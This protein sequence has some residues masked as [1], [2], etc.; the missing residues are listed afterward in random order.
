MT[1]AMTA[2][3][4]G[5]GCSNTV[6]LLPPRVAEIEHSRSWASVETYLVSLGWSLREGAL[7]RCPSCAA[8]AALREIIGNAEARVGGETEISVCVA[9]R[10]EALDESDWRVV[11]RLVLAGRDPG[12]LSCDVG[13]AMAAGDVAV[14]G[15][16]LGLV[17]SVRSRRGD[18]LLGV[19]SG[20]S[21]TWRLAAHAVVGVSQ[22]SWM[23]VQILGVA[24]E[25]PG[26]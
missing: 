25:T 17:D 9:A 3:C 13:R 15:N 16:L 7:L 24:R 23:R 8:R 10:R 5:W 4:D 1:I 2:R 20:P 19:A 22:A 26:S 12:A 18:F 6:G 11:E 14:S 21:P